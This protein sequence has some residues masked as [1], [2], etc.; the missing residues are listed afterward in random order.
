[1][2]GKCAEITKILNGVVKYRK[3][4][5]EDLL[6]MFEMIGDNPKVIQ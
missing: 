5:R 4:L 1:M 6:H 3:H 2:P